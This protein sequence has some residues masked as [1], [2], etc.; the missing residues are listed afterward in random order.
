MN[1]LSPVD[2]RKEVA[3]L[4]GAGAD[5][6]YGGYVSP[7][8]LEKYSLLGSSNQRYF[9]SAQVPD[10]RELE[11]IVTDAHRLGA[12]FYLAL[13]APSYL[14]EQYDD[15]LAEAKRFVEMGV[16]AFIV[17]SLGLILRLKERLPGAKVHLSTLSTVF[18]SRSARF[19]TGLGV[20]R[21]VLPR[22]LT[23]PEMAGIIKSNKV[24]S[25]DSFIMIG[26]CPNIEGFC[27]FTHN[28]PNLV[29]P[30]EERY[31]I[32]VIK[33]DTKAGEIIKAQKGWSL[34]NRRQACGLC[35]VPRLKKAGVSALKLVGRGGP[36]EV[37]VAVTQAVRAVLDLVD[38]GIAEE[39]MHASARLLYR[40]IFG[41]DCN[42]Y[43]C[44]FPEVW[45]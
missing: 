39:E 36:T 3:V 6:L 19:Y 37:K 22:E 23:V 35:A 29:W 31:R 27:S 45:R 14:E 5:E 34:V 17:S 40:K 15:I 33:G 4:L 2:R 25:F 42:P 41:T 8:W 11:S 32:D 1:I 24:A 26:K 16:D 44:Y 21:I 9:A 20:N 10:L 43:I 13:N 28:S 30:C 12:R 38:G 18:N 7:G